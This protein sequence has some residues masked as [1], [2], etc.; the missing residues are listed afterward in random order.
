[1]VVIL[2]TIVYYCNSSMH[3]H[4]YEI[5]V[6]LI[7]VIVTTVKLKIFLIFGHFVSYIFF[8]C[9]LRGI[10]LVQSCVYIMPLATVQRNTI[11]TLPT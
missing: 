5:F 2:D 1:M 8:L 10:Q 6:M 9:S 4:I 7:I 11:S 3:V